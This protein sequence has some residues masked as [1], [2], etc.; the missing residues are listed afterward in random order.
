[1]SGGT[2]TT[3]TEYISV[4]AQGTFMQSGG[5]HTVADNLILGLVNGSSGAYTLSGGS[6]SVT[7]EEVGHEG[8]GDFNQTG[9]SHTVANNLSLG[10]Q[11]GGVGIY[12]L[13]AGSL[14]V[15]GNEIIGAAGEGDFLQSGGSHAVTNNFFLGDQASA[16]ATYA[17]TGG[18]LSVGGDA[19]I[20]NSG[21]GGFLQSGGIN[22]LANTLTLGAASGSYGAYVL[23]GG[24]L[25]AANEYVGYAGTGAFAQIGGTHTVASNLSLGNQADG[26]GVYLLSGGSL[27]VGSNEVIGNLGF[28]AIVQT[29]GSHAVAN[30]LL[31]GQGTGSTGVYALDDGILSVGGNEIIGNLGVGTFTQAG[32]THTVANSLTLAAGSGS[33]GTYD[34]SGGLLS[35]NTINVNAGGHIIRSGGT[36]NYNILNFQGGDYTGDLL[37]Q[38]L[39]TG[40]GTINGNLVNAGTVSPGQS[41]GT[42][43]INGSYTQTAAGA[44]QA[45]IASPSSYDRINVSGTASL[46]GTLAPSLLGGY[47]PHGNQVFSIITAT[48]G[49]TGSFSS[50]V[51]QQIGL[52]L[53]W[54]P[55]YLTNR[56]DLV[57]QRSYTNSGLGLTRNQQAVGNMLNGVAD[58]A[59]GDLDTVLSAL[60]NLGSASG[61]ANAYTQISPEK[62]GALASLGLT[63]ANSQMR[64]LAQWITNGR[65]GT[66]EIAA[67]SG[68]DSFNLGNSGIS[69]AGLMLAYGGA[70]LTG[71]FGGRKADASAS[72]LGFYL[73]PN[74]LL[75]SQATTLNQ[76]GYSFTGAGFTL[77]G[78]YRV[79]DDLLVGVATG[80]NHLG[81]SFRGSGGAI[82]NNNWPITAYAAYLPESFY[83]FG[84]AGYS[85]NLFTLDRNISFEGISRRA[86]SSPAGHQFNGYGETGYDL[87]WRPLVVTPLV[88]LAYSQIWVDGFQEDGAGALDL[89]VAS[90]SAAS[91]QTGV[92]A[93]VSLPLKRNS[94]LVVPQVYATYQHEFANDSR[95]LDARLS[96]GSSTFAWQTERP[97]R[98]FAVVG[99]NLTLGIRKNVRAQLDYNA[100]VGR[101]NFTA[102]SLNAGLRWEF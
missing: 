49:L 30:D 81:A 63:G 18:S 101:G 28:G 50:I 95:G 19:V 36:L 26:S 13:D 77:G 37:N 79:R 39:I 11:T 17:L 74:L 67:A 24:S 59:T 33:S 65:F 62:A 46:N 83:A 53:S 25:A 97:R 96:Q 7:N 9:G 66:R 94:T 85:L 4:A 29:G 60:D 44:Y 8:R 86:Q 55:R 35:A 54:Q 90:Q 72:P 98:D 57:V 47:R 27:S 99:A 71:L 12:Q 80:Y 22:T 56:V 75:G 23:D 87:K 73:L 21:L 76:T 32:G 41:P 92:G 5:V 89:N 91:L 20:G 48:D 88:S 100:E 38:N 52:T 69:G 40:T 31:L 2:L 58:S 14:S 16:L 15:G 51:N 82:V 93:K 43:T 42:L 102:H 61:L 68:L 64:N 70:N 45:E 1:L 84:A 78:D 10:A 3:A 34:L 6:L